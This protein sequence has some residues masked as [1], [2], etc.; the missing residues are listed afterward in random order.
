MSYLPKAQEQMN[1]DLLL[2]ETTKLFLHRVVHDLQASLAASGQSGGQD[3]VA[4]TA[5]QG[6]LGPCLE[7][8][9]TV[10]EV[11]DLPDPEVE[12]RGRN[13]LRVSLPR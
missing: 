11:L 5:L 8:L 4:L 6:A 10:R 1:G 2:P 3:G 7:P 9:P 13:L 12:R